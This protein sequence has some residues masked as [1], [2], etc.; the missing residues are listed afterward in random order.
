MS[1]RKVLVALVAVYASSLV[2]LNCMSHEEPQES[3]EGP[4]SSVP[5]GDLSSI[6]SVMLRSVGVRNLS[7]D[8]R[9]DI[10]VLAP[11]NAD[12]VNAHPGDFNLFKLNAD[13]LLA[14][15]PA[16]QQEQPS[17][18]DS[19]PV[20]QGG[21]RSPRIRREAMMQTAR[22]LTS[23]QQQQQQQQQLQQLRNPRKINFFTNKWHMARQR[24]SPLYLINGT[25]CRFVNMQPICTTLYTT[26][27]L[28]NQPNSTQ[29]GTGG[30]TVRPP[31]NTNP[32]P[33]PG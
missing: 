16:A 12:F 18:V 26:G 29:F 31:V 9:G 5:L 30:Q 15:S 11:A 10:L 33:R 22:L 3:A 8:Q 4:T 23:A 14:D 25:V 32:T 24:V 17:D 19:M 27:L 28:P 21:G 13:S 1:K 2:A 7:T 6:L 20:R